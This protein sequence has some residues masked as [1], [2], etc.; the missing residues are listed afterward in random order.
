[1]QFLPIVQR[2][3]LV[4]ARKRSTY[5]SRTFSAGVLLVLFP[6]VIASDPRAVGGPGPMLLWV[7]S[8]FMFFECML[9]GVRY[10]SDCL[11]E[12]KREGTLG[13]L[14]LTSL[15]GFDIVSGKI[16]ARSAPAVYNLVAGIPILA[17]TL[18]VG[19]VAGQQIF[20]L[21]ITF[22]AAIFLSL[23]VGAFIS[24]RSTGERSVLTQTLALLLFLSFL[25][26][27]LSQF[28]AW[29]LSA[30]GPK[31][32]LNLPEGLVKLFSFLYSA[33]FLSPYHAF[34]EAQ[35][36]FRPDLQPTLWVL[37]AI[38]IGLL[39]YASWRIHNRFDESANA[40]APAQKSPRRRAFVPP[41][42]MPGFNYNPVLWLASGGRSG[43]APVVGLSVLFLLFGIICRI[44][45]ENNINWVR[46]VLIFGTLGAHW[47]YKFLVTAET[48]R[49][50]NHDKRSGALEILLTTPIEAQKVV[51]AQIV[52]TRRR[53][54]L[55]GI[56]LGLMNTIWMM[57]DGFIQ[58]DIG[59]LLPISVG[60]IAFDSYALAWCA[61]L[62]SIR[63]DRYGPTVFRTFLQV[64]GVPFAAV[65][66]VILLAMG[67]SAR[68]ETMAVIFT[69]WGIATAI[70]DCFLVSQARSRLANLRAL[71]A[72]D[73]LIR[74]PFNLPV[75]RPPH[76]AIPL[77]ST[78]APIAAVCDRRSSP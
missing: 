5:L 61:V 37:L 60:L 2:E 36:G 12:E 19:G 72:G 25:P 21:S 43:W 35:R 56:S 3:L 18:L 66:I 29:M 55:A 64:M 51:R 76:R 63:G 1:M 39:A 20:A 33:R 22:V 52:T 41:S 74:R 67:V 15:N 78:P 45:L 26:V 24:S 62:N 4:A 53:W 50:L 70:F 28:S 48:C 23:S 16:I 49:Q 13:L 31:V 44:G 40:I 8:S 34:M 77:I 38:S 58:D 42:W 7:L 9:A 65:M 69:L 71:A 17:L 54:L 57:E 47:L 6:L 46:F 75:P 73:Q 68:E 59:V 27:I 14:F 30:P 10:T 32:Y 11:S